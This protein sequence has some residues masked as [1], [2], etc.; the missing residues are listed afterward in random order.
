[1]CGTNVPE[2]CNVF[3]LEARIN[4]I[5]TFVFNH[6][7]VVALWRRNCMYWRRSGS[8]LAVK[9]RTDAVTTC[10]WHGLLIQVVP[11]S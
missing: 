7:A 9:R 11:E 4:V 6:L 1:M 8:A 3:P 2:V 10:Y 5:E